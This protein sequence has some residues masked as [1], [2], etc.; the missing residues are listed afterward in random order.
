MSEWVKALVHVPAIV[1]H[2]QFGTWQ[3]RK[4]Y[5]LNMSRVASNTNM[6]EVRQRCCRSQSPEIWRGKNF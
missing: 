3:A 4:V 5:L 2:L 6:L 1:R